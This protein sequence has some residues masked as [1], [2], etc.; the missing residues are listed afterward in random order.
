MASYQYTRDI[1]PED[2]Q[3]EA[4]REYTK[5]EKWA[6]WWD[7]H[8]KTVLI[9]GFF[10]A[11]GIWMVVDIVT[12]NTSPDYSVAIVAPG[13]L[14]TEVTTALADA[15]TPYADDRNGDG[16][17]LVQC[18]SYNL[19]LSTTE[20]QMDGANPLFNQDA[21]QAYDN[22]AAA[23]ML[24]GDYQT[25][26]SYVF[27]VYDPAGFARYTQGLV[28]LDGTVPPEIATQDTEALENIDWYNMVYRWTDCPVLNALQPG[29]YT[30][31][32]SGTAVPVTDYLSDLYV[33]RR[34]VA[35]E[36]AA[37][38]FAGADAF[39]NALTEGASSTA[40]MGTHWKAEDGQ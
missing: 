22:M 30:D 40:G 10:I 29:D 25:N 8:L 15:L 13:S 1:K 37:E 39:W 12:N 5:K 14:P 35:T 9:A 36:D 33:G 28:Y 11:L 17:V 27:L 19:N 16:E 2:L 34:V 24:S 32:L 18:V 31:P 23:T 7:Y 4:P 6:N 21:V 20:Q 26:Q 3:P 38:D